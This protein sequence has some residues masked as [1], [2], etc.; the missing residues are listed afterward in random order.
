MAPKR[1]VKKEVEEEDDD[2]DEEDLDC[3]S[4]K[5][6]R[7]AAPKA[8][9]PPAK[10]GRSKTAAAEVASEAGAGVEPAPRARGVAKGGRGKKGG[11]PDL[12]ETRVN[13][14]GGK[15]MYRPKASQAVQDRI[16]RALPGSSHRMFL[17]E[18]RDAPPR[19]A[20]PA[21]A[22]PA[23]EFHVLGATGN[24]YQVRIGRQPHCTCPDFSRGNLCKHVLFTMLRVLRRRTDDPLIWQAALTKSEVEQVLSPFVAAPGGGGAGGSADGGAAYDQ[25]VLANMRVRQR[26]A[27]LTGGAKPGKGGGADEGGRRPVEGDCPICYDELVAGAGGGD[28]CTWCSSCGN[29]VHRECIGR[30]VQQKRDLRQAVTCVYCRQPW[31]AGDEAPTPAAKAAPGDYVNLSQYSGQRVPSNAELYGRTSYFLA[32]REGRMS[33]AEAIR[34]HQMS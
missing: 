18:V 9:A 31:A 22:G 8:K 1:R 5:R 32:A 33:M 23:K 7:K 27:Q 34:L 28:A 6:A 14:F 13:E 2:F 20:S 17:V 30:W 10:K 15:V 19:A 3:R 12:E 26:Y 24:V 25:S 29:N 4:A 16:A 21:T 11:E